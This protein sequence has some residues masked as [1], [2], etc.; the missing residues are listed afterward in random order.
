MKTTVKKIF[1]GII[2]CVFSAITTVY[3]V[4]V[5][6]LLQILIVFFVVVF[7]LGFIGWMILKKRSGASPRIYK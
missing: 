6:D 1:L 2:I 3:I 4:P 5:S 7:F